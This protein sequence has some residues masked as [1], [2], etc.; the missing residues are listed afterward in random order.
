MLSPWRQLLHKSHHDLNVFYTEH[1]PALFYLL[2]MLGRVQICLIR[3]LISAELFTQQ[4]FM[5]KVTC[6]H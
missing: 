6:H 1:M 5:P 4:V 2:V 3:K